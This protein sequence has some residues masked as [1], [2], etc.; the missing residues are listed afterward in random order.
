MRSSNHRLLLFLCRLSTFIRLRYLKQLTT[1][2]RFSFDILRSARNFFFLISPWWIHICTFSRP[3]SPRATVVT[4]KF[5][6]HI[7]WA[8]RRHS[9]MR[10]RSFFVSIPVK[11]TNH[12]KRAGSAEKNILFSVDFFFFGLSGIVPKRYAKSM[13]KESRKKKTV[14]I[15]TKSSAIQT[16]KMT[17][18]KEWKKEF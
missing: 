4:A 15:S 5:Q 12:N 1:K 8:A 2:L 17:K 10:A 13:G 7:L 3:P 11:W 9:W 16:N 18:S 6:F 14:S